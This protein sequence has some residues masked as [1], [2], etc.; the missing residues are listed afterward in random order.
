MQCMLQ[1]KKHNETGVTKGWEQG[2]K[3]IENKFTTCPISMTLSIYMC[4]NVSTDG[5][6]TE[7]CMRNQFMADQF[8]CFRNIT[9]L[10]LIYLTCYSRWLIIIKPRQC[11]QM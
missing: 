1:K 7:A 2:M 5:I 11:Y 3:S 4:V 6:T 8:D 9:K 10:W